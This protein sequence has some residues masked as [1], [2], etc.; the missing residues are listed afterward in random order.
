MG[1]KIHLKANERV[2][3]NGAI[4]TVPR[5]CAIA[6]LN[7]ASVLSERH[8]L[9]PEDA[10]TPARRIYF[11]IQSA[12]V[13]SQEESI[14][15]FAEAERL[16]AEYSKATTVVE[17]KQV[18]DMILDRIRSAKFYDALKIARD[19]INY[20]DIVFAVSRGDMKAAVEL[21]ATAMRDEARQAARQ[22][23][24]AAAAEGSE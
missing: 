12:Y 15:F 20:E 2:I 10:T 6:V 24:A 22:L 16:L 18:L 23:K 19:L 8:I 9:R 3:I 7:M 21:S 11:A 13:A 17:V 4:I 1:L 14:M 5:A